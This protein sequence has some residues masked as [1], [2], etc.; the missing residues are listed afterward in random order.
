MGQQRLR[1][2]EKPAGM[3]SCEGFRWDFGQWKTQL[4]R[5]EGMRVEGK[6]REW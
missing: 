4:D 6:H 5:G 2:W 3:S 1:D